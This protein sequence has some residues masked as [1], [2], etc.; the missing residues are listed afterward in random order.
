M[1]YYNLINETIIYIIAIAFNFFYKWNW[2]KKKYV[3]VCCKFLQN[4]NNF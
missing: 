4:K 3:R 1:E 2:F